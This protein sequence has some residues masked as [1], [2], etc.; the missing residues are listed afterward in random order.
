M[1]A[2]STEW[3]T[4]AQTVLRHFPAGSIDLPA[5]ER[6]DNL[7]LFKETVQ[8]LISN[9]MTGLLLIQAFTGWCWQCP[10][11][12]G[13][14]S[15]ASGALLVSDA[16]NDDHC[17]NHSDEKCP[18]GPCKCPPKCDG[19]CTYVSAEKTQIDGPQLVLPFEIVTL[20]SAA[21]PLAA[22]P[23]G[24]TRDSVRAEPP[25]RLHLLHQIILI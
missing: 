9:L 15:R 19:V 18:P 17:G 10:R 6:N 12:E 23:W 22:D 8:V 5:R 25:L 16:C 2:T 3:K 14:V 24:C 11:D 7:G 4:F 13:P 1:G 21:S 20:D